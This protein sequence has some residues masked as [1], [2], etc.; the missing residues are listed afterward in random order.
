MVLV[1][2]SRSPGQAVF[3]SIRSITASGS[4]ISVPPQPLPGCA[5]WKYRP[6]VERRPRTRMP[7]G[8]TSRHLPAWCSLSTP[9]MWSSTTITSSTWPC[10][11]RAKMPMAAEPQPTRIRRSGVPS[12][13]GAA[14]A[15]STSLGPPSMRDLH[16]LLVAER[17]HRQRR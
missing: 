15:C 5:T 3:G 2:S 12:T 13:M 8:G 10:H 11:C 1:S 9:V 7:L 17:Q 6:G 14:P 4:V 16:R